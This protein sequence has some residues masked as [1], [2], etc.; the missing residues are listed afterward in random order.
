MHIHIHIHIH[1]NIHIHIH[2]HIHAH[3]HTHTHT[4]IRI[5]V[6][7]HI[8]IHIHTHTHTRARAHTHT[9]THTHTQETQPC[10]TAGQYM[11][12]PRIFRGAR[13]RLLPF[14]TFLKGV[15]VSVQSDAGVCVGLWQGEKKGWRGGGGRPSR[16]FVHT[17]AAVCKFPQSHSHT[18][19]THTLRARIHQFGIHTG[20]ST[21]QPA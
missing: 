12:P 5:H 1:I 11:A 4:H 17:S 15:G 16:H 20:V 2:I 21:S 3:A 19:G 6:H 8:H 10:I 9:H 18:N 14:P 7:T 13:E